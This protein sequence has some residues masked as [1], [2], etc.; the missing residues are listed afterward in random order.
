[1]EGREV[2]ETR[3]TVEFIDVQN[4]FNFKP[5]TF[6]PRGVAEIQ[7]YPDLGESTIH[8]TTMKR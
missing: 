4:N 2:K 7:P 1:M 5:Y 8:C 3:G 6:T